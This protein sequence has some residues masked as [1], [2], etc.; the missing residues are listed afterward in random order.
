M[1]KDHPNSSSHV[2]LFF[3]GTVDLEELVSIHSG[4]PPQATAHAEEER[5]QEKALQL[6]RCVT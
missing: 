6:D 5:L 4:G 2:L 3:Q 1:T